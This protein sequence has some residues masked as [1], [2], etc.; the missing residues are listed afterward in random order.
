[1]K[2]GVVVSEN[3]MPEP[4]THRF[5]D[6]VK[7]MPEWKN[8]ELGFR[9]LRAEIAAIGAS[10]GGINGCCQLPSRSIFSKIHQVPTRF[11]NGL[12]GDDSTDVPLPQRI[13]FLGPRSTP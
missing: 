1:M 5:F 3:N 2:S 9:D 13:P 10:S 11:G 4:V 6:L 7:D 8:S 12:N